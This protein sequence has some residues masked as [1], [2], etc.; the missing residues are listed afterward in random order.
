V[1][2]LISNAI[3]FSYANGTISIAFVENKFV[4][5]TVAD[6]GIGM[7]TE[8]MHNLFYVDYKKSKPERAE[9]GTGLGLVCARILSK[10][11]G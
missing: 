2:N 3:K 4:K 6:Q 7:T 5:V 8:E 9:E 1:W 10:T 11:W